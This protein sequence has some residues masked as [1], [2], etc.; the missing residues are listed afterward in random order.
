MPLKNNMNLLNSS[1]IFD[2]ANNGF[3]YLCEAEDGTYWIRSVAGRWAQ[4]KLSTPMGTDVLA[5]DFLSFQKSGVAVTEE[6]IKADNAGQTIVDPR[7]I[8][9]LNKP[10]AEK[11]I[12]QVP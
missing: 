10:M 1:P 3:A 4:I 7:P 2:L 12:E 11:P 5:D 6:D 8:S 9:P